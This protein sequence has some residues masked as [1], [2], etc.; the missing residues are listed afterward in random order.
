[1]LGT[2]RG[3]AQQAAP[4]ASPQPIGVGTFI[5]L[6]ERLT[7]RTG[8][9][10]EVAQIYLNALLSAPANVAL[11]ADLSRGALPPGARTPAHVGLEQEI[12]VAWYTGT[13]HVAGEPRLATHTGA[14][15][16]RAIGS[17]APGTCTGPTGSWSQPPRARVR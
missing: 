4:A 13:Y 11:L 14:L 6:S 10:A 8:L 5:T 16:W 15:M 12:V 9:D 17:S 3:I 7:G 2:L 1:M